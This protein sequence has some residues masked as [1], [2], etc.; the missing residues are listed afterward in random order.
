MERLRISPVFDKRMEN[1]DE[2]CESSYQTHDMSVSVVLKA[3]VSAA[4]TLCLV[5]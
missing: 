5:S 3:T 4:Y 1:H 2:R